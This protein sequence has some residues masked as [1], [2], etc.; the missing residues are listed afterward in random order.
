MDFFGSGSTEEVKR[1]PG[2]SYQRHGDTA[3]EGKLDHL[4]VKVVR[5]KDL[6]DDEGPCG[7]SESVTSLDYSRDSGMK[8]PVSA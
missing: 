7:L 8:L 1:L 2:V 3:G 6:I 4:Q 5:V